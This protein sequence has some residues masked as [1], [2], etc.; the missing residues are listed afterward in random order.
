[1]TEG[2]QPQ[3]SQ[4]GRSADRPAALRSGYTTG[5]CATAAAKA[6]L[7]ALLTGSFPSPVV[8][9]LPKGQQPA[10]PLAFF[11]LQAGKAE[12][13][14][15]K[16][17]G[18]DPDITHG[19]L[20]KA[21]VE[22]M[23]GGSG[24]SFAAGEGVGI[25]TRPGLLLPPG[26]AAIN[27]VPRQMIEAEI[28]ALCAQ[29]GKRADYRITV[30]IPNGAELAQQT[31]NPRLG[32]IGGLSVLGT[33]GIVRPYSCSAWI[34][35]IQQGID[36]ARAN[37]APH[38]LAAT[39]S[40]SQAAAEGFYRRRGAPV[41]DYALIDMG[42]FAG[43]VLKYLRRHP[44][45]QVSLAGGFAKFCKLAQGAMD[46]HS[47]RS[48]VDKDFVWQK[49]AEAGLDAEFKPQ[50]LA[51]NSAKEILDLS[52]AAGINPAIPIAE[53]AKAQAV[54]VSGLSAKAMNVL[55]ADRGGRIIAHV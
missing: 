54:T 27:P 16:D 50:I 26:E 48:Q 10:F 32:I 12:A 51:A 39:G 52:L 55:I 41:A 34:Y 25:I 15:I 4:T 8:I 23:P 36:V 7:T 42:D 43:A 5:A 2:K 37:G 30:S 31:W 6:A 40:T 47:S 14:I 19:A 9:T 29:F 21:A 1:M 3:H 44:V 20:I 22:P 38:I 11:H 53:A 28:R 46:L 17:A 18:D 35:A 33:T 49:A 13:G 24:I 45:A